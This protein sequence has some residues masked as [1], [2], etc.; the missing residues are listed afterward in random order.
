[1]RTYI[2]T[3]KIQA[4]PLNLGDYNT[5]RGWTIPADEN[6]MREGYKVV[7]PDG[8]VSW[9]PKE[10]FEEAY[11]ELLFETF[12]LPDNAD[13]VEHRIPA[14]VYPSD[15]RSIAVAPDPDYGGAHRYQF[16]NSLGFNSKLGLPEI[17][18]SFQEI[19]FVQKNLD[20]SMT[21]GLQSEQLLYCLIDRHEKLNAKFPSREG[22]LAITKMQEAIHWLEARVKERMDRQV[23]GDLKK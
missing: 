1:M 16:Q 10:I 19:Q 6:P 21:A 22:A 20:G 11:H 9:S 12:P 3:K 14:R 8:Y 18:D 4:E 17:A 13:Q 2:G 23:M 7:Y 5:L 15:I